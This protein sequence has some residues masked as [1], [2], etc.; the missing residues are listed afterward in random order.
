M[1]GVQ[2]VK[3]SPDRLR[4]NIPDSFLNFLLESRAIPD[5]ILH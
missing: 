3:I 2:F 1:S 4:R 5:S